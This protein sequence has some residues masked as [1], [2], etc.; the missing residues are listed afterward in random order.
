LVAKYLSASL[1]V[2]SHIYNTGF[3]MIVPTK[4]NETEDTTVH[5]KIVS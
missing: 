5:K 2:A 3:A 1:I 4:Q